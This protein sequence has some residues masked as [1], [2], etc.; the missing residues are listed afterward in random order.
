[1]HIMCNVSDSLGVCNV[2]SNV[3]FIENNYT[4]EERFLS[5][6]TDEPETMIDA[7]RRYDHQIRLT[8]DIL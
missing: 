2:T 3:T 1:M 8:S 5:W 7:I 4:F 6:I